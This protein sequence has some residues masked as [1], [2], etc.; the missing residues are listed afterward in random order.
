MA[1]ISVGF[2]DPMSSAEKHRETIIR[3]SNGMMSTDYANAAIPA[4]MQIK[5]LRDVGLVLCDVLATLQAISGPLNGDEQ[6]GESE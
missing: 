6:N 1:T 3:D 4:V 5:L 2:P